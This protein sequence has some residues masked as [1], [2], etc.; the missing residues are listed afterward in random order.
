MGDL[1]YDSAYIEISIRESLLEYSASVGAGVAIPPAIPQAPFS[2]GIRG[3]RALRSPCY[4]YTVQLDNRS[5]NV[6]SGTLFPFGKL[7]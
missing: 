3:P 4:P 7:C 2:M 1:K 6:V 5:Y